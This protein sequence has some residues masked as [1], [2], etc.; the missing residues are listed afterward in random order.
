MHALSA[1]FLT[2]SCLQ[3]TDTTLSSVIRAQTVIRIF[4]LIFTLPLFGYYT[5]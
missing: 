2:M 4:G 5:R 1:T 3:N